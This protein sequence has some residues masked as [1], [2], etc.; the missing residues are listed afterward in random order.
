LD[1]EY[2][3]AGVSDY[4]LMRAFTGGLSFSF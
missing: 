1:P 3:D 4:P 2:L